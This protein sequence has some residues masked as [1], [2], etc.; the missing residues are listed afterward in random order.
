MQ[1]L[2]VRLIVTNA[3]RLMNEFRDDLSGIAETGGAMPMSQRQA[4]AI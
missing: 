4:A 3:I 2:A 1:K